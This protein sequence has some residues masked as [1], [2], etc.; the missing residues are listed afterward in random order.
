M[1]PI[2]QSSAWQHLQTS[3]QA[4]LKEIEEYRVASI[5]PS[6]LANPDAAIRVCCLQINNDE[7]HAN[8]ILWRYID[9]QQQLVTV[10]DPSNHSMI[11]HNLVLDRITH[12]GL[13]PGN[14]STTAL[15]VLHQLLDQSA[16]VLDSIDQGLSSS[17]K[18]IQ[19]FQS[20]V[21][22]EKTRGT[23]DLS[24]VDRNLTRLSVPLSYVQQSLDDL[25]LAAI[26][27]RRSMLRNAQPSSYLMH[28]GELI[29]KIEGTQR[30]ARFLL[31]RQRFHW[32]AAGETV[33]MSDLN[34]IKVFSV[35]WAAFIPGTALINWYGQNFR[36]MPEL[37]W[38]GSLWV[39]L[40]AVLLLTALPVIMVKQS[41][42]LR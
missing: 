38:E 18:V 19:S 40:A 29:N 23:E 3:D 12:L 26:R 32:R 36:V 39:Q 2:I 17:M 24:D 20:L 33:A 15:V 11:Q 37:S 8:Y 7:I 13:E 31:E 14:A 10:E 30:R 25:Q 34:V 28:A 27:L 9:S 22:T 35:L 42:A 21:G 4:A 16:A 41:G 5:V 1:K 6:T